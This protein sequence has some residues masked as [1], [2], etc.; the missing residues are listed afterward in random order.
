M[1]T[2]L[3]K[4]NKFERM[5][6]IRRYVNETNVDKSTS[7]TFFGVCVFRRVAVNQERQWKNAIE[8]VH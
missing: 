2:A 4:L 7:T 5:K 8:K 6:A 1:K 3:R